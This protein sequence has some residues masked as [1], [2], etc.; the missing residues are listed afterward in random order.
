MEVKEQAVALLTALTYRS[1]SLPSS[2]SSPSSTVALFTDPLLP[3]LAML[4]KTACDVCEGQTCTEEQHCPHGSSQ[5]LQRAEHS[6]PRAKTGSESQLP[7]SQQQQGCSS[8]R[9][10][11]WHRLRVQAMYAFANVAAA[12]PAAKQL[13]LSLLHP[14]PLTADSSRQPNGAEALPCPSPASTAAT[15]IGANVGL[16][17]QPGPLEEAPGGSLLMRCL[18]AADCER[19]QVAALWC[20][21][22]LSFPVRRAKKWLAAQLQTPTLLGVLERL[23]LSTSLNIAVSGQQRKLFGTVFQTELM[24]NENCSFVQDRAQQAMLQLSSKSR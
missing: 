12:G 6:T 11:G 4:L 9:R 5:T 3:A 19:L 7:G 21:V 23:Q 20:L 8:R 17:C 15:E 22:N 14:T 24:S 2:P 1:S 18:L 16:K 13:L 10:D